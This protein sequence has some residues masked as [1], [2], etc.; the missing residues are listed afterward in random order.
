MHAPPPPADLNRRKLRLQDA[1]TWSVQDV[2]TCLGELALGHWAPVFE[3][4]GVDG[5][6]L[7]ELSLDDL[8][9]SL[10]LK[11][12][13]ARKLMNRLWPESSQVNE[14]H[15]LLVPYL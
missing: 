6:M 5:Q 14:P 9:S 2:V 12:L 7:C 4:N 1:E 10:G 13:Q 11:P 8:T 15:G 3:D